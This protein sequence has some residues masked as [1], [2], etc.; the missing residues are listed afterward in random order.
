[1]IIKNLPEWLTPEQITDNR[2]SIELSNGSKAQASTT[3][4]DAA[5]SESLSL[6]VIDEWS[7]IKNMNDIWLAASPT[8]ATG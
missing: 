1:M 2:Q 3:T 7:A 4:V 6:L 8:L 5:R